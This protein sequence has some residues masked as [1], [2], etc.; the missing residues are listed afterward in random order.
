V[1]AC[2]YPVCH[3]WT[4]QLR[5]SSHTARQCSQQFTATSNRGRFRLCL[6]RVFYE[7]AW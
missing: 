5:K 1:E 7:V 4:N 3:I 2:R 6:I